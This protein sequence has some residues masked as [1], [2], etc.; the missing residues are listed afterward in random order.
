MVR[1]LLELGHQP[2][3]MAVVTLPLRSDGHVGLVDAE[4]IAASRFATVRR[5][6]DGVVDALGML[7]QVYEAGILPDDG[8]QA[9]RVLLAMSPPPTAII[10][11]SDLLASGLVIGAKARGLRVP[12]DVSIVGF[13]GVDLPGIGDHVL[14]T[15]EQPLFEKGRL[16]GEAVAALLDGRQPANVLLPVRLRVGTTSGP[17]PA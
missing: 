2:E 11:Q 3:R 9:A 17:P 8:E 14:T 7:P 16:T 15:V 6:L 10:A 5:R 13:D 4:R 12:D 1:H